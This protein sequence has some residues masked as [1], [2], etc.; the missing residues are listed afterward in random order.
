MA[1][2]G[3]GW[4]LGCSLVLYDGGM[5]TLWARQLLWMCHLVPLAHKGIGMTWTVQSSILYNMACSQRER[6]VS[7]TLSLEKCVLTL[8]SML[9]GKKKKI[10]DYTGFCLNV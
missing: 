7:G 9:N 6:G 8:S 10:I 1:A 5:E 3:A 2:G 4:V